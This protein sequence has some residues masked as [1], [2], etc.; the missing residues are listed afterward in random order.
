MATTYLPNVVRLTRKPTTRTATAA[1]M[2]GAGMPKR[3]PCP[4]HRITGSVTGNDWPPAKIWASPLPPTSMASVA[5]IGCTPTKATRLPFTSPARTPTKRATDNPTGQ[6]YPRYSGRNAD[7]R[8]ITDPT[9]RSMPSV[10]IVSATPKETRTIGETVISRVESVTTEAKLGVTMRLKITSTTNATYTPRPRTQEAAVEMSKDLFDGAPLSICV[11]SGL[12]V[13]IA[14]IFAV[15]EHGHQVALGDLLP[16]KQPDHGALP[17]RDHAIAALGDLIQLRRDED[18]AQSLRREIVH[19]RLYLRFRSHVDTAGRLVQYEHLGVHAQPAGQQD[20]LLVAA[21]ELPDRLV[22]ARSLDTEALHEF[23]DQLVL[24]LLR[25]QPRPCQPRQGRSDDVLPHR[26]IGNNTLQFA[27]LGQE[28]DSGLYRRAGRSRLDVRSLNPHG[29]GVERFGPEDRLGGLG[30]AG[31]EEA[32][33]PDDFARMD[34]EGDL[35][36]AWVLAEA[37]RHEDGF[38]RGFVFPTEAGSTLLLNLGEF[39]AEHV[40]DELQAG[41]LGEFPGVRHPPVAQDRHAVADLVELFKAVADV[42]H[43][44]PLLA[45]LADHAEERLHLPRLQRRGR[46]VHDDGSRVHRDDPRD[47]YHLLNTE[48]ERAQGSGDVRANAVAFQD[49]GRL[50]VHAGLIYHAQR[51]AG[52][53]PEEHVLGYAEERDKVDLL[54]YGAD[55]RRLRLARFGERGLFAVEENLALVGPVD[56]GDDLDKGRFPGTVLADQGVHLSR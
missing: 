34:V 31:T 18:D 28:G 1:T 10:P 21:G 35:A 26:E 53:A 7:A 8:A 52:L 51:V 30:S 24:C 43:T 13:P 54:V 16:R 11:L 56:P 2:T 49:L 12:L 46:L 14:R 47:G 15:R 17:Q 40:G 6:P 29:P 45:Q 3:R 39:P 48:A 27:V 55:T 23:L 20:L 38:P 33:E 9:E 22:W 5:M 32:G 4:S 42:D 25:N 37:L 41:E 36:Q 50:P 44:N 19:D